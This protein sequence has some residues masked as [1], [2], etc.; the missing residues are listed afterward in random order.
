MRSTTSPSAVGDLT[1][2]QLHA[3]SA[4]AGD[5]LKM[6]DLAARLDQA[7]SSVTRLVDRMEGAGL[8]RRRT[9]PPDRRCVVAELTPE[10]RRL[11]GELERS[12]R[13]FLAE[14]LATLPAEERRELVR[15]TAKMT[16]ALRQREG[17]AK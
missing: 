6:S 12:R 9:S 15:L 11:A 2:V 1:T 5:D 7:E 4:L 10:G 17:A 3:L 13:Q 16:E 8:V 14:L